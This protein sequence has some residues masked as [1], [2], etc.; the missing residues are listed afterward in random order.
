MSNR[1]SFPGPQ[2][3]VTLVGASDQEISE[4][5]HILNGLETKVVGKP[6]S[7]IDAIIH[8]ELESV[9]GDGHA[10]G[11]NIDATGYMD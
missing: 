8:S 11:Y 10:F 3:M 5:Q 6:A 4:I 2:C 7:V 1:V 9:S